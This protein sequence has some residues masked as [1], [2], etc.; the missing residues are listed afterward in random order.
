MVISI[1]TC[2]KPYND[3]EHKQRWKS[4]TKPPFSALFVSAEEFSL[5]YDGT[6]TKFSVKQTKSNKIKQKE[7][8]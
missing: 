8:I 5:K 6:L 7:R 3:S 2:S 4:N 1:N